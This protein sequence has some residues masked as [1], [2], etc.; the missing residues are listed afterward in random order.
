MNAHDLAS[1]AGYHAELMARKK[2]D[3]YWKP[4]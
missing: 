3:L 2:I 1:V 4:G